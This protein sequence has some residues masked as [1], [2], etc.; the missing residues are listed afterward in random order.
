MPVIIGAR[1]V[2]RQP[3]KSGGTACRACDA[4][5]LAGFGSEASNDQHYVLDAAHNERDDST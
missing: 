4:N 3:V 2:S 5:T 1:P